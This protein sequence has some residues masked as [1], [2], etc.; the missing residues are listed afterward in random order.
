MPPARRDRR[1]PGFTLIELVTVMAIIAIL[2]AFS[3][4]AVKGAQQR[5]ALARAKSNLAALGTALEEYKRHYG[6]YP[7]LAE[8]AQ[9]ALTPTS[10]TTGPGITTA[11]AKLF[12]CLTGVFGPRVFTNDGRLNGPNLLD[13]GKFS[14]NGTLTATFQVVSTSPPK[15]PFKQEQNISLLD[16]WGRRYLYYY[17]NARVPALWQAPGY[18]LYSTGPDGQHTAPPATGV[19]TIAQL[20]TTTNSDNVYATP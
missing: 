4:G 19:S 17:K 10:T 7:Q 1:P 18:V 6:D 3:F 13:I 12:N 8:F 14:L 2:A 20:T 5:A 16:P 9:A 15:P 11:Q